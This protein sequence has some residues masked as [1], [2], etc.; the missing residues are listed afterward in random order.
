MK[1]ILQ[2]NL[3]ELKTAVLIKGIRAIL[4][5]QKKLLLLE[6]TGTPTRSQH[7]C[8]RLLI[9]PTAIQDKWSLL[10]NTAQMPS[11][12]IFVFLCH[13]YILLIFLMMACD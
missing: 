7:G 2:L 9:S 1:I 6:S 3:I 12:Y 10:R 11:V 8:V 5:N 13:C 4:R